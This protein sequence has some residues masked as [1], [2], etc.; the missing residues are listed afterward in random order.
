MF[1]H[2]H[3][4]C[5]SQSKKKSAKNDVN[6]F[7]LR[8]WER[9]SIQINLYGF[10]C[11]AQRRIQLSIENLCFALLYFMSLCSAFISL[12][13]L[14]VSL[15]SAWFRSALPCLACE[16]TVQHPNQVAKV[17]HFL[18]FLKYVIMENLHRIFC[19]VFIQQQFTIPFPLAH[20]ITSHTTFPHCQ[21]TGPIL[22]LTSLFA[23]IAQHTH[24][25]NRTP[26][27]VYSSHFRSAIRFICC[28][29]NA[30]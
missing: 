17:S 22:S 11:M 24:I 25:H 15:C 6:L 27:W 4:D 7:T 12:C 13:L 2:T 21:Q 19:F 10:V 18:S 1:P 26:N 30:F 14:L 29:S 3:T 8:N 20:K 16:L 23:R 5:N 9:V 28:A